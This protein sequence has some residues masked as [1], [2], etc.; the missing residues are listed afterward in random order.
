MR[1]QMNLAH[2]RHWGWL[3]RLYAGLTR[4]RVE[5]AAVERF[6]WG[7]RLQGAWFISPLLPTARTWPPSAL[8]QPG[9][10]LWPDTGIRIESHDNRLCSLQVQERVN[11]PSNRPWEHTG[12]WDVEASKFVTQSTHRWRWG[13]EP[14]ALTAVYL[15]VGSRYSFLLEAESTHREPHKESNLWPSDLQHSSSTSDGVRNASHTTEIQ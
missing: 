11:Y 15:E 13:C 2:T 6:L 5:L 4:R 12:H 14:Y 7:S 9:P 3:I 10:K 1:P 8:E